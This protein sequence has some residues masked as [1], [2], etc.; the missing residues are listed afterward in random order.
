MCAA[1]VAGTD[2]SGSRQGLAVQLPVHRQRQAVQHHHSGRH[3][4]L[5]QARARV[6]AQFT[7]ERA[8]AARGLGVLLAVVRRGC[9]T[10][11]NHVRHQTP[12][13]RLILTDH[14]RGLPHLF[15][16]EQHG[17]HL[18][19]LDPEPPD[20]HLV[21][22]PSHELQPPAAGP[23]HHVPGP[24]HPPAGP[25]ERA[26]HEPLGGQARPVR[27]PRASPA[28]AT[29]SSPATPTGTGLRKPS[30]TYTRV[31]SSGCPM[32]L[33]TCSPSTMAASS[34]R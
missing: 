24:V 16:G 32:R 27:V 6:R 1:R 13:V 8:R 2:A 25:L 31:L 30:R 12:V 17:L 4:V 26:G 28:P 5:G 20:L 11:R 22:R 18:T 34:R 23:A 14:H 7:G 9:A 10:R 3:H 15:V 21:V 29:Y 33:P 19:R